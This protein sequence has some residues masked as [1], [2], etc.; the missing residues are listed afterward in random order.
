M[1]KKLSAKTII[2]ISLAVILVSIPALA[3][4]RLGFKF[5][6][7]WCTLGGG[8]LNSGA[9]GIWSAMTSLILEAPGATA[10]GEFA[11][12]Y[13]GMDVGGDLIL[14]FTRSFGISLGAGYMRSSKA[15]LMTFGG[16]VLPHNITNN[17]DVR[18]GAV[19]LSLQARYV[20]PTTSGLSVVFHAGPD[21]YL[22]GIRSRAFL[23]FDGSEY[24][25][26]DS[27]ADGTGLGFQGGMGLEYDLNSHLGLF[28]EAVGRYAEFAG[29]DGQSKMMLMGSEYFSNN[30]TL[31]YL[32]YVS[33][34]QSNAEILCY[35]TLPSNPNFKNIREAKIDF[36]GISLRL[37]FVVRLG[38]EI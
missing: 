10:S 12:V 32:D 29:F 14:E 9:E 27:Q 8:D 30:G 7:G 37:G 26:I 24:M 16:G 1:R 36:S 35:S 3:E 21:F 11:P 17:A 34:S 2:L 22:A 20:L 31:Y 23:E 15:S 28:L 38:P 33:S 18:A 25:A 19:R 6:G 5:Y 4:V 13:S